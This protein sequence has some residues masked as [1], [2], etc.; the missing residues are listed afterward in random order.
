MYTG[1]VIQDL[2]ATV[3]RVEQG[4]RRKQQLD[5][6]ELQMLFELQIPL[7]QDEL[8]FVGAA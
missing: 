3:E 8:V 5:E 7:M 6:R 4:V 2:L 1:T